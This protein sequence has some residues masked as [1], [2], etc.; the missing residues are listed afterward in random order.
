MLGALASHPMFTMERWDPFQPAKEVLL[1]IKAFLEVSGGPLYASGRAGDV[2]GWAGYRP[3]EG[4]ALAAALP[5]LSRSRADLL[6]V[7]AA[8]LAQLHLVLDPALLLVISTVLSHLINATCLFY[9][10][11]FAQEHGR[12]DLA[13]E[14]NRM[15]GPGASAYLESEHLLARLEALSGMPSL[16]RTEGHPLYRYQ[17]W[18]AA[19]S[20]LLPGCCPAAPAGVLHHAGHGCKESW[21]L[22][23]AAARVFLPGY[24]V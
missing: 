2:L 3:V 6:V 17:L 19:S 21:P 20:R 24:H 10:A 4:A 15:T 12:V 13:A 9:P 22:P 7:L 11:C 23:A 5:P 18:L 16:W 1:S 14:R 8:T